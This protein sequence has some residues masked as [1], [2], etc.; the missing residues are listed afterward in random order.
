MKAICDRFF[1]N[2]WRFKI[3][4]V[5]ICF[6]HPQSLTAQ[7]EIL[8]NNP[9]GIS[10]YQVNTPHFSII[11]NRDFEEG[12]QLMA[13]KLEHL[14][15]PGA[16]SLDQKTKKISVILQNQNT[17]P[18]GFVSQTPRRSEF[19]TMPTQDYNF[20]G[21]I[22]WLDLLAIHEYR[23]V[24]QFDKSLTGFNKFLHVIFGYEAS[25][26]MAH[27]AVP[28]WYWEGDAVNIETALTR[29][30]RGRIPNF[31]LL[32]RTNTLER[33]SFNYYRQYL[34]SF[35]FNVQDHYVTGNYFTAYLRRKYGVKAVSLATE[36]AWQ[37]P[38]LP[39]RFSSTLKKQTGKYLIPHY[40]D[41]MSELDSIWRQQVSSRDFNEYHRINPRKT[42]RYADYLYPHYTNEGNIVALKRG[43]GDIATFVEIDPDGKERK[44]FVPG[45]LNDSG[46]L[47][48][49]DN[50]LVWNE[51]EFDPRYRKKTF[52]VIKL[53]DIDSKRHY[54]L[55]KK[56]RFG[57]AALSPDKS[58]LV[59]VSTNEK[60]DH[61]LSILNANLGWIIENIPNPDNDF[62]IH[63][64][65]SEDGL[66][67]IAIRQNEKGKTIMIYNTD[68]GE[69]FDLWPPDN[70]NI[71]YPAMFNPFIFYNSPYD[72]IDNIYVFNLVN[73]KR[74]RITNSKYGAYNPQISWDRQKILYNDFTKYGHDIVEI[75]FNPN[76]WTSIEKVA[77]QKEGYI[78]PV[79]EQ[80][81]NQDVFSSMSDTIKYPVSR[82][83]LSKKIINPF[84]WGPII[85]STDL[86][87]LIGLQSQD[88]MSTT[89]FD[90]GYEF[91][92]NERNGRWRG[93]ISYQGWFPVLNLNGYLGERSATERFVLRDE[94]GNIATDT[95]TKVTWKE[96]GFEAGFRV[97]LLLTR[98][99]YIQ[100]LDIGMNYNYTRVED[101]SFSVRYPDVQGNGD[102]YSN[103][104]F[105]SYRRNMKRSKRDLFGKF[106]QNIFLQ[107]QHTP[108]QGD[109]LG[110]LF[111]GELRF[112]FPGFFRHHS[113]QLRS[114]YLNQELTNGNNTYLF[115]SPVLFTRGYSY[116]IFEQYVNNSVNYA[117][118]LLYPD[119]HIGPLINLQRIYTNLFFDIGTR[120]VNDETDNFRSVGAEVSFDFNLLRFLT[121]FNMGFRY[122]YAIDRVPSQ[123][124]N[125]QLL[126]GNFGF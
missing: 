66:Y 28:E 67:I 103:T 51:F 33:G 2:S 52:S 4:V 21:T 36:K 50:T 25:S 41:M 53:Y 63:P 120:F 90:L 7:S 73:E 102:L 8:E 125:F 45:F 17:I 42:N 54:R 79:T 126:I 105:F 85:T 119:L 1:M 89:R 24:V 96:K 30:G 122:S 38:F 29:S 13:N 69:S 81:G 87:F 121:L 39:F 35:R 106:G 18:N 91:N 44:L 94:N 16:K 95:T 123:Q 86:E 5:L 109:Y 32:M 12:A 56:T 71:G 57:S 9:P 22:N 49:V 59:T 76:E 124:H 64:R 80:E 27:M 46:M 110:G 72:G 20:L 98:S 68:T 6:H 58:K 83:Y 112:F 34:R 3:I 31:S 40:R 97:P 37:W 65:W 93:G 78:D 100:N 47:S 116:L 19:Y 111:A 108:Y 61:H 104:Y 11:F 77:I 60:G 115:S 62:F 101:Y 74:Y 48:L 114:S 23:H 113:L 15:G 107:Y 70:E 99:K 43:I 26:S 14:Y 117:L 10:W 118:P 88:I 92:A 75:E 55:A 84:S 82:Y